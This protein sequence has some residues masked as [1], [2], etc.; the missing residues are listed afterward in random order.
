GLVLLVREER[1]SFTAAGIVAGAFAIGTAV[2]SPAWG[3]TMDVRGPSV[4]VAI[5]SAASAVLIATL[6]LLPGTAA[7]LWLVAAVALLAGG[8]LPPVTPAAR[9]AW[10]KLFRDEGPVRAALSFDAAAM[11][12]LF[13]GGPVLVGLILAHG[14]EAATVLLA[15]LLQAVGGIGYAATPAARAVR[16]SATTGPG[17]SALA[18]G[19]AAG[20]STASEGPGFSALA[21]GSAAGSSTASGPLPIR[22]LAGPVGVAAALAVAFGITDT[23]LAATAREVLHDATR[24]GLLFTAIAG[25]SA[26]GGIIFG[27]RHLSPDAERR[28]LP[29]LLAAVTAG[30]LAVPA[31]LWS[32]A[33]LPVVLLLLLLTGLCIAPVLIIVMAQVD[34]VV[35]A[36]RT[37][38]AQAWLAT[39]TLVGTSAGTPVGGLVVDLLGVPAAY[40]VAALAA[41]AACLLALFAKRG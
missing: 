5:G 31:A 3:R 28:A 38:E 6:A 20:S 13:V 2:G 33:A 26:L 37:S 10:R 14:G 23:A 25:G 27:T 29:V 11:E 16:P 30:L 40:A 35:P 8:A 4:P 21:G 19:S 24:V 9:A 7:P 36:G 17:S 18:G 1:G 22:R 32:G 39:A 41:G 12:A 15:A 34:S